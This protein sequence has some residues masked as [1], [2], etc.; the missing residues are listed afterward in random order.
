[1]TPRGFRGHSSS[2]TPGEDVV[3]ADVH[4]WLADIDGPAP[5]GLLSADEEDRAARFYFERHRRRFVAGRTT[6]RRILATYLEE[7]PAALQFSYGAHGKPALVG[8]EGDEGLRFNLA[9]CQG[10][11]IY[12]VTRG[13]EVGVDIE[14]LRPMPDALDLAERFFS[15]TERRTLRGLLPEQVPEGFFNAWTRKEAFVKAVGSGLAYPLSSFDVTLAPWDGARLLAV[16]GLA[17][18]ARRFSLQAF[19]PDD[20]HVAAVVVEAPLP[21]ARLRIRSWPDAV[22]APNLHSSCA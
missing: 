12:A 7:S 6:L 9:H 4:V 20:E 8:Q 22:W 15:E 10:R 18:P 21:E 19:R 11:A 5:S 3:A 16:A 2:V 17:D 1:L 13:R 14:A